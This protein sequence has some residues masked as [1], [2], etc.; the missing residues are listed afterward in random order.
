MKFIINLFGRQPHPILY[1]QRCFR[2]T[3]A[4]LKEYRLELALMAAIL[5]LIALLAIVN[6][7]YMTSPE[8]LA[9]QQQ[10]AEYFRQKNAERIADREWQRLSRKHGYPDAVIIMEGQPPYYYDKAG[11]KCIFN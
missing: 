2:K 5:S 11:R 10:H 4:G 9:I 8:N 1:L 7:S 3:V 6:Y